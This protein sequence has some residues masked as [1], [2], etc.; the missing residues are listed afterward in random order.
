MQA[1]D[2]EC[3]FT[4]AASPA[5]PEEGCNEE[6]AYDASHDAADECSIAG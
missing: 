1:D 5:E 2:V 3:M 6:G 4:S